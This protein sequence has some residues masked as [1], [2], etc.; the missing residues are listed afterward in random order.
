MPSAHAQFMMF[1]AVYTML[2]LSK[3][4]RST[5]R[6]ERLVVGL[7]VQFLAILVT[8]SRVYLGY[9]TLEQV[10][11]GNTVGIGTAVIWDV[12]VHKVRT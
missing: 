10:V 1:F 9:H 11:V 2:F 3:R 6:T 7:G 4:V 8:F 12:M 5:S